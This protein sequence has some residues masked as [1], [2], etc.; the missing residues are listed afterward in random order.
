MSRLERKKSIIGGLLL[1][2]AIILMGVLIFQNIQAAAE[3]DMAQSSAANS[4]QQKKN[5]AEEV[6]DACQ[7]GQIVMGVAGVDLCDRAATI[8]Q[9]PVS[10]AGPQGPRG[11]PGTDGK[12]GQPGPAGKAGT[13]GLPGAAGTNGADSKIPGPQGLPGI[14]GIPGLPGI[15]GKDSTVPGPAGPAGANGADGAN[16]TSPTSLTFTDATGHTYTCEPEPPGSATFTCTT[17]KP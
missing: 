6:A 16:G 7:S 1:A 12:D 11:L 4:A 13:D 3:R 8:A 17:P 10:V 9:Q 5:L 2:L 15:D 14:P